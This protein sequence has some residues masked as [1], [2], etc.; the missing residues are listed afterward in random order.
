MQ[1]VSIRRTICRYIRRG[2][3][4]D[5]LKRLGCEIVAW[6]VRMPS[7]FESDL[8]LSDP[9]IAEKNRYGESGRVLAL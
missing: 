1:Q 6:T 7:G 3:G 4:R 2:E 8:I 9:Y 5:V